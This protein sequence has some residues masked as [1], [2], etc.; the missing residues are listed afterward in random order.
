MFAFP[1]ILA[2]LGLIV[3]LSGIFAVKQ[4]TAVLVERFG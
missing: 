2:F 1:I 4:Q 3:L